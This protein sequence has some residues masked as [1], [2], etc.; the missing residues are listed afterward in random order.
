M[1]K[2]ILLYTYNTTIFVSKLIFKK[3]AV[4]G[5][6]YIFD[7]VLYIHFKCYV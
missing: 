5:G 1:N 6:G 3:I 2:C 7:N 4:S